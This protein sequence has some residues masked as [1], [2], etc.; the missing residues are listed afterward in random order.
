MLSPIQ[1]APKFSPFA[2]SPSCHSLSHLGASH[3]AAFS[4]LA[5]ADAPVL[6]IALARYAAAI[7]DLRNANIRGDLARYLMIPMRFMMK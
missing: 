4:S 5:P 2:A 1:V 3:S 7:A 6:A